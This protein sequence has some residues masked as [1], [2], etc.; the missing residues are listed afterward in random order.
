MWLNKF[1]F[2]LNQV[3]QQEASLGEMSL[4]WKVTSDKEYD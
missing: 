2:H 3:K 4:Y 1:G